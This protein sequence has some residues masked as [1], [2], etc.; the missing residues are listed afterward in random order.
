MGRGGGD[1]ALPIFSV[2]APAEAGLKEQRQ[3]S[4]LAPSGQGLTLM[5][6]SQGAGMRWR[7]YSQGRGN[8]GCHTPG[9]T[10]SAV[11]S[12]PCLRA[13]SIASS[14][15]RDNGKSLLRTLEKRIQRLQNL[16]LSMLLIEVAFHSS[17]LRW[18]LTLPQFP[19]LE[20]VYQGNPFFSQWPHHTHTHSE[21]SSAWMTGNWITPRKHQ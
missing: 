6:E 21:M 12:P 9:R 14:W 17:V 16:L 3:L 1:N 19:L 10:D 2:A 8:V 20:A 7:H 4:P 15:D 5:M 18:R 13:S 11:G